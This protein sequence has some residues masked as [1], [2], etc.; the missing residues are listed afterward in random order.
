MLGKSQLARTQ[1]SCLWDSPDCTENYR[2]GVSLHSHTHFSK[3]LLDFIPA[4]A[5]RWSLLDRALD[6]QCRKS[7]V[8]VD[9]K[10]AYWTPPLSPRRAFQVE[11]D[12][13]EDRLDLSSLVS[14]T[15]HD[16]IE[17][18][19]LLRR[20][21]KTGETPLSLEWSVP[22]GKTY[23]HLGIHNLPSARAHQ[24][25]ADLDRFRRD[26][27]H[28]PLTEQ[29]AL[30]HA[31]PDVLIVLNHPFWDQAG[32]GAST[33]ALLLDRFLVQNN[34][35][36]H[37]FELNGMRTWQENKK[38]GPLAERWQRPIISGGDRHAC[39]PSA[40][41]N[42]SNAQSFAEFVHE[43]RV[44]QRSHVLFM[45]QYLEPMC[46]R[47]IRGLLEVVH[48][49]PE[50]PDGS[51]RW[52][53]RVF[54]PAASADGMQPL[55]AFWQAPPA[56]LGRFFAVFRLVENATVLRALQRV[57]APKIDL[58]ALAENPSQALP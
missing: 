38:V 50:F 11:R 20:S 4:F 9:F 33:H 41:V 51:R 13:I 34:E 19:A 31:I 32:L 43:I 45:P 8:P 28:C 49:Y 7:P 52:D 5:A 56:I 2:T 18:P 40:T 37:A 17:A 30:L 27:P 23:F 15:D 46:V 21:E 14:L 26:C 44:E 1:V 16:S 57:Y 35:F 55:S 10:H 25:A 53:D 6:R 29:L 22:F 58:A 47:V 54:H 36:L 12:Q 3:E 48:E 42:L 24:I 39:E